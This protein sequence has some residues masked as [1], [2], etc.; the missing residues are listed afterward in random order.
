[1]Y[2]FDLDVTLYKSFATAS[3]TCQ[4][5]YRI[6]CS[7]FFGPRGEHHHQELHEIIKKIQQIYFEIVSVF[8][9]LLSVS[10]S[11]LLSC[12]VLKSVFH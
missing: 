7:C 12:S 5:Y 8:L 11:K 2:Y 6:A 10:V 3:P 9:T 1:M 4:I